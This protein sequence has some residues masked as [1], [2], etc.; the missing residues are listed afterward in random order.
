MACLKYKGAHCSFV[1]VNIIISK[2]LLVSHTQFLFTSNS[3]IDSS[4]MVP[5]KAELLLLQHP[6][7]TSAWWDTI[8]CASL[9][10]ITQPAKFWLT[11]ALYFLPCVY[12]SLA[13]DFIWLFPCLFYLAMGAPGGTDSVL[14]FYC[15]EGNSPSA[16]SVGALLMHWMAENPFL[17]KPAPL[18]VQ[19]MK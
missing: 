19:A 8:G 6:S 15:S 18:L 7:C 4:L 5:T 12:T 11:V 16:L 1:V 10:Q 9:S 14:T 17:Q 2:W 3:P 13:Y